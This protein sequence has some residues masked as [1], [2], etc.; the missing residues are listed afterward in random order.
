M[1]LAISYLDQCLPFHRDWRDG[2]R[3]CVEADTLWRFVRRLNPAGEDE[4]TDAAMDELRDYIL[5]LR[6]VLDKEQAKAG[7]G[8]DVDDDDEAAVQARLVDYEAQS[9]EDNTLAEAEN[10]DPEALL[11]A[12][13]KALGTT[14]VALR[15]LDITKSHVPFAPGDTVCI[16]ILSALSFSR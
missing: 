3:C 9:A 10:D 4:K 7:D 15:D 2:R 5:E 11:A 8:E 12:D 16:P 14:T 1:F 13:T 6:G